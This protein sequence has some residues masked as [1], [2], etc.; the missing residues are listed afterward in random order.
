MPVRGGPS[1]EQAGGQAQEGKE[2]QDG[3]TTAR[4][5]CGLLR[6]GLLIGRSIC[7]RDRAA[8]DGESA[9]ATPKIFGRDGGVGVPDQGLMDF[10]QALQRQNASGLAIGAV[11]IGWETVAFGAAE[12]LGLAD[13]FAARGP[14]LTD[15]PEEGP[16][17]QTQIPAS[18]AGM[19]PL[20][21]LGQAPAGNPGGKERFELRSEER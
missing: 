20:I 11:F 16:E 2:A 8:I 6:I 14:S 10:L 9:V 18:V 17:D 1:S 4:F 21:L 12:S 19:L 15:L 13:G 5:L 7:G 3:K